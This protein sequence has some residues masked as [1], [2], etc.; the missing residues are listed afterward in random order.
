VL[1]DLC[2]GAGGASRGF[3][4]AGF[5]VV[6]VD[7]SPQPNYPYQFIQADALDVLAGSAA[8]RF[9]DA[10]H[11]SPP[12]QLDCAYRRR[13]DGVGDGYPDLIAPIR[14]ALIA[15]G[16][17]YVIE[18]V[19]GARHKLRDPVRLCGSSFGLDVR[20]HRLFE[21][22]VPIVAPPCD[23]GWQTPRFPAAT[24]RKPMSRC[25]VEIGVW[26]IPLPMQRAAMGIDWMERR[27]LSNAIPPAY[28]EH[29]GKQLLAALDV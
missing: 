27:E 6:G 15:T 3:D 26:R 7:L 13:G 10:F 2:C 5:H 20:R 22:N 25:T 8:G 24:N 16:K 14:E 19:T 29:V 23:H 17:P 11:A 21:S 1:L 18:N 9:F 28:T 12:C 4:L